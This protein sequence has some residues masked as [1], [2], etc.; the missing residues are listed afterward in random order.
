[1][2]R[3]FHETLRDCESIATAWTPSGAADGTG[4]K[5]G[6]YFKIIHDNKIHSKHNE[7]HDNKTNFKV[8][9]ILNDINMK[10]W[11]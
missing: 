10:I 4:G 3:T 7:D 5:I 1:M 8:I 2:L 9:N 11:H 6:R